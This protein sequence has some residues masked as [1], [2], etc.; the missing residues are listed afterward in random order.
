MKGQLPGSA[1]AVDS[2]LLKLI[3]LL[4][5]ASFWESQNRKSLMIHH[6][7]ASFRKKTFSLR[8]LS[9]LKG[10]HPERSEGP[11]FLFLPCH[12]SPVTFNLLP[13]SLASMVLRKDEVK[14]IIPKVPRMPNRDTRK[15]IK[16]NLKPKPILE[17]PGNMQLAGANP[18]FLLP[19]RGALP[20]RQTRE[21]ETETIPF[22]RKV[23]PFSKPRSRG[24]QLPGS[25]AHSDALGW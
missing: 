13:P 10:C 20:R 14:Q 16:A 2:F 23:Y 1:F 12:L 15:P 25:P 5:M 6:F 17:M 9:P 3:P 22:S 18:I 11:V 4:L 19:M 24:P 8:S 7:L 21:Q